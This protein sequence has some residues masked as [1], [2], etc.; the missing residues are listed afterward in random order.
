MKT[1]QKKQKTNKQKKQLKNNNSATRNE[2]TFH[3][4][5]TVTKVA[6]K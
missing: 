6:M 3:I 4:I 5:K 1:K 2:K